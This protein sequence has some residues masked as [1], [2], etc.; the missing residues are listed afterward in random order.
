[1]LILSQSLGDFKLNSG[2]Y[3]FLYTDGVIEAKAAK[4]QQFGLD[5]VKDIIK[6]HPEA[7]PGEIIVY[8][9]D[10]LRDWAKAGDF[11][12]HGGNFADDITMLILRKD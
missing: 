8:I 6:E 9:K 4:E 3:L 5:R 1:M 12:K 10:F 2:D 11:K 7:Q